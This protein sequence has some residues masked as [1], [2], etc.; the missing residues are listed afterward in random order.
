[1]CFRSNFLNATKKG[2]RIKSVA[3]NVVL[4][5]RVYQKED[6]KYAEDAHREAVFAAGRRG[7]DKPEI[8]RPQ[9]WALFS[10]V[11]SRLQLPQF[12][13]SELQ[14]SIA[15]VSSSQRALQLHALPSPDP[16]NVC[17]AVQSRL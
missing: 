12:L 11:D 2:L 14:K 17:F 16:G 4:I 8:M 5:R 15:D 9:L 13:W 3:E 6:H 7:T 1:L 10:L